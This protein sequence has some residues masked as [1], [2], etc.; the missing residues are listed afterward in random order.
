MQI[1][2]G[3]LAGR[4]DSMDARMT[5][6]E[7]E[8]RALSVSINTKLDKIQ[9]AIS[10]NAGYARGMKAVI[11]AAMAVASVAAAW[12]SGLIHIGSH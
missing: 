6:T 5:R 2:I 10:E 1:E 7:D 4:I 9:D 3:R 8:V 12:F 11:T